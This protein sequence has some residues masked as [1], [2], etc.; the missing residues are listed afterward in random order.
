MRIL[1]LLSGYH[2]SFLRIGWLIIESLLLLALRV[3]ADLKVIDSNSGSQL[4]GIDSECGRVL[5]GNLLSSCYSYEIFEFGI[6]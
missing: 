2:T 3:F 5:K 4:L 1:I 6:R